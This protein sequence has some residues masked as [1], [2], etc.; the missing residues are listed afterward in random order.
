MDLPENRRYSPFW[1]LLI[2]AWAIGIWLAF[3][4]ATSVGQKEA[5]HTAIRE[6]L[7]KSRQGIEE[8]KRYVALVADLRNLAASDTNANRIL[9]EFNLSPTAPNSTS[10]PTPP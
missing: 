4:I 9:T 2:L 6:V 3:H 8:Q 10:S 5:I 1:G 7:P